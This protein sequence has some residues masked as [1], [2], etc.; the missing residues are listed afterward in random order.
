MVRSAAMSAAAATVLFLACRQPSRLGGTLVLPPGD[1][2]DVRQIPV[3]LFDEPSVDSPVRAEVRSD[4]SLDRHRAAFTFDSLG[5]GSYYILAW[6]DENS[7]DSIDDGDLVGVRGAEFSRSGMGQPLDVKAGALAQAGE[8]VVRKLREPVKLAEGERDSSH[9]STGFEFVFNH[10]LLLA[11]LTVVFPQYGSYSD[12]AVPGWKEPD[13][14]Y[15]SDGWQFGGEMP[16]GEH[17]VRFTGTMDERPFDVELRVD[18][19]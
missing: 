7:T 8:V 18:V 16:S 17:R 6:A 9:T 5:T 2:G 13:T 12:P 1:T 10:R 4:T 15:H 19:Q 11:T 3:L 14:L